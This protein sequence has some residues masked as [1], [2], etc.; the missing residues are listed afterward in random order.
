MKFILPILTVVLIWSCGGNNA[1]TTETTSSS[2]AAPMLTSGS[3]LVNR[4]LENPDFTITVNG[5]QAGGYGFLIGFFTD[6]RFKVDSTTVG[7]NG[8]LTFK[9]D[10]PYN[11]GFYFV[12]LPN[13][14]A[15][16]LLLD[17]DQTFTMATS[18]NDII[19]SMQVKGNIDNELLYQNLKFEQQL[20]PQFQRVAQQL[21]G[22][23]E[24]T[25]EYQTYK[26]E[27]DQLLAQRE[28]HLQNFY[29]NHSDAFFT[30]FKY[31]GQNPKAKDFRL[32]DGTVDNAKQVY[33]YRNE[34][35]DNVDFTD[36][37]LLYTPVI[38]NKLSKYITQLTP[39]NPDSINAAATA[40]AERVMD[41]PEYYKFFVNW[42]VLNY[43]PTKTTLMDPEA[44]YVHM[45]QNYFTYDKV[46]WSDSAEV[47]ALQ[48][49]ANE[50]A[51]SIVGKT[52]PNVEAMDVSG[53]MR[54]IAE[55][56]APYIVVYM[57]NPTCEHCIEETPKL[58]N[59]Y[60]EWKNKGVEVYAIAIDTNDAEWKAYAKK[61][62]MTFPCVFDPTNRA[63]Y[64][65]YYVDITP[66]IY[67]IN[68][69]RKIIAKNLKVA[70]IAEVI[71]RDKGN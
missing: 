21:Q 42:I 3:Q 64:G 37:R 17:A 56:K 30:K 45:I 36:E 2:A 57:F 62:G 52:A 22:V 61:T 13:N 68:P 15:I 6:Q 24:G 51:G 67:V 33:H 4:D 60:K 25:P 34:L 20:Q 44:V 50:M 31:S 71:N 55:I 40:L 14:D 11:P 10:T 8:Q 38:S 65:K 63:I 19:G 39:Q 41:A 18:L 49:R 66:E 5:L 70:Q 12:L 7:G 16:Q 48:L 29:D 27:Q 1:T 58:V 59:W 47:Y 28:A 32:P 69:D 53:Q 23:A 54:S 26:T 46:T 9:R 43:E 35:W